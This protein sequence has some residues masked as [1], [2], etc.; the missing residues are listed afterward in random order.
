VPA[1]KKTRRKA[2]RKPELTFEQVELAALFSGASIDNPNLT[3][4]EVAEKTLPK[5]FGKGASAKAFRSE[6]K[7]V[8]DL[9]RRR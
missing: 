5:G 4:D 7:H 9:E 1:K 8:F 6:A 2:K 3:F